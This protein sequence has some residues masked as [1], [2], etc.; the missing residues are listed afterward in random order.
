MHRYWI[1]LVAPPPSSP[2]GLGCGVTARDRND[3]LALFAATVLREHPGLSVREILEDVDVSTLDAGHVLPN[4][5]SVLVRGVWFP[6]GY[7]LPK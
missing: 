1:T 5:G 3:A 6:Q 4:M 2:L 7:S